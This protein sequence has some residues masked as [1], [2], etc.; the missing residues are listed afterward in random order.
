ME[1]TTIK[2][3]LHPLDDILKPEEGEGERRGRRG[4]GGRLAKGS[5]GSRRWAR[6]LRKPS[7]AWGGCWGE[8]GQGLGEAVGGRWARALGLGEAADGLKKPNPVVGERGEIGGNRRE[9][10][11]GLRTRGGGQQ[12][13]EAG[14]DGGGERGIGGNRGEA[15]WELEKVGG[16]REIAAEGSGRRKVVEGSKRQSEVRKSGI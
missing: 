3:S 5:R 6:D 1:N 4:E 9:A 8:A 16:N 14:S 10:G 11:R 15:G 13:E 12:L 7:R 2:K